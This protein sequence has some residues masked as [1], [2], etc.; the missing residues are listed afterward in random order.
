MAGS[1]QIRIKF[2]GGKDY[3]SIFFDGVSLS[4]YDLK[5]RII[6]KKNLGAS[7]IDLI[8]SDAE[9]QGA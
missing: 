3:E 4:L 5:R 8:I 6:E 7:G 9:G 1:S 2:R